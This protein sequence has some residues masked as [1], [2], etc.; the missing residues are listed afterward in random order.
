MGKIMG[1][2]TICDNCENEW[3]VDNLVFIEFV[4]K[5]LCPVCLNQLV[6]LLVW[7]ISEKELR[8]VKQDLED[9]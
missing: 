5:N 9:F 6:D 2:Q 1:L 7:R 8:K 3:L 4:D